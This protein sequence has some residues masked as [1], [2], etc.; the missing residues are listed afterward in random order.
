ME[1]MARGEVAAA[2][3]ELESRLAEKEQAPRDIG[4]VY[5]F[6]SLKAPLFT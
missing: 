4:H 6:F 5:N 1:A 2:A 3:G